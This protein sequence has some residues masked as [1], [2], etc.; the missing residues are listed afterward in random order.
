MNMFSSCKIFGVSRTPCNIEPG[1][2]HGCTNTCTA[3]IECYQH[4]VMVTKN[5]LQLV[6]DLLQWAMVSADM[7]D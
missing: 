7:T 3:A 5:A 1:F 4:A 2:L 6:I